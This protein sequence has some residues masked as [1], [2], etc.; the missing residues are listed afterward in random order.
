MNRK[1]RKT[2]KPPGKASPGKPQLTRQQA[3]LLQ[4]GS[5]AQARGDLAAAEAAYRRLAA[6]KVKAPQPYGNLARICAQTEREDEAFELWNTAL[7]MAPGSLEAGMGLAGLYEQTGQI[8]R[9]IEAY[10][11]IVTTHPGYVPARYLLANQF[12]ARG[13]FEDAATLYRQIMSEQPDYAQAHFTY[14]GI[15]TYR[16]A[17]DPHIATMQK[18]LQSGG[19]P[20]DKRTQLA[21]ALAKAFEDFEDY[22][23]AFE[24]LETGNRLRRE[25]FHYTI[26]S[27]AEL[28]RNIIDTFSAAALS[29]LKIEADPSRRPI[30][31]V[32]MVRSG[33]TLVEKILASHSEV[34]GAGELQYIWS[35]AAKLFLKPALRYQF[36]PLA[37]YPAGA[38]TQLGKAYLAKL[39]RLDDLSPRVT[40]KMPFNMMMIGLIRLALPNAKIVH[41]VRDARDTCLSIYRQNFTTGNY[42]FAYDLR[43][44][45]L[46]HNLYRKLMRHWDEVFPGMIYDINYESLT[47]NPEHEI[48]GLLEACEL[49]W[50]D[51]CLHFDKSPG[52]VRTASYFQ[53]RQPMYTRSVKLWRRYEKHLQPLLEVLEAY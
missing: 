49:E 19:L 28:I 16:D 2:R 14:A 43:S 21:F 3:D 4:Q 42:R 29:R 51:D 24:Y 15:H 10:R 53:V 32:G 23:G 50:Q 52:V 34:H 1:P 46:F 13:R 22:D 31:V 11:R 38:F 48:R 41:C 47:H 6:S 5:A 12:K 27:D 45:G 7:A 40:D 35:L 26:D 20:A 18:L 37:A 39:A 9:A 44:I 30:F 36:A 33:T 25:G 8:D 17:N